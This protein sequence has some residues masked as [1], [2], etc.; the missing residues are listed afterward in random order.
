M[1]LRVEPDFALKPGVG[2]SLGVLLGHGAPWSR[3]EGDSNEGC[4]AGKTNGGLGSGAPNLS[5]VGGVEPEGRSPASPV[6]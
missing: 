1:G 6:R 3:L 4:R 5:A 2:C